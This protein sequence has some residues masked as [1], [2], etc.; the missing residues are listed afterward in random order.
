MRRE[1]LEKARLVHQ[2]ELEEEARVDET[3][4]EERYASKL[5]SIYRTTK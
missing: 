3:I 5:A 4:L 1:L 2:E